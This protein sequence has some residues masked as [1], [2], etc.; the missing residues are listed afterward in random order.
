MSDGLKS[1]FLE[2]R[3]VGVHTTCPFSCLV[4]SLF[5]VDGSLSFLT[6]SEGVSSFVLTSSLLC[7]ELEVIALYTPLMKDPFETTCGPCETHTQTNKQT[8]KQGRKKNSY[9][10]CLIASFKGRG[11]THIFLVHTVS[12]RQ[13]SYFLLTQSSFSD[14]L[15]HSKLLHPNHYPGIAGHLYCSQVLLLQRQ[16]KKR[17]Q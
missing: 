14:T 8:N 17:R 7:R 9:M 4:K 2:K 13:E 3:N 15:L 10:E 12:V 16:G 1:L 6:G 5:C 11:M